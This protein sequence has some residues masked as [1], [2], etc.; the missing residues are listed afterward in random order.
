M[1]SSQKLNKWML[2]LRS[3]FVVFIS[4]FLDVTDR[5][6]AKCFQWSS[7]L[8]TLHGMLI[9]PWHHYDASLS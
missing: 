6:C 9:H 3:N 1:I 4:P 2:E 7:Q 5:I 8:G